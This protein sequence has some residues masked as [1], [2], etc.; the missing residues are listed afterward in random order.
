MQEPEPECGGCTWSLFFIH[1][2]SSKVCRLRFFCSVS[3]TIF[4][5]SYDRRLLKFIFIV[6]KSSD[7][8][9]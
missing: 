2:S 9:L 6:S 4:S 7:S 5:H 1:Q 3:I 8:K